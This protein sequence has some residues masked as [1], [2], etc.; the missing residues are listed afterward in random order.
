MLTRALAGPRPLLRPQPTARFTSAP[1][2]SSTSA[3][4]SVRANPAAH[5]V[6]SSNWARSLKPSVAYRA[7]NFSA[8]WKKQTTLPSSA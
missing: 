2:R 3:V 1:I 6:P 8:L 5:I 7:L 4:T